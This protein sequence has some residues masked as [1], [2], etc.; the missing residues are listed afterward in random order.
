MAMCDECSCFDDS[1]IET[2]L[3]NV[4]ENHKD[5]ANDK[6][7]YWHGDIQEDY[8]MPPGYDCLCD[9]CFS[10]LKNKGKIIDINS[11]AWD[12]DKHG[13]FIPYKEEK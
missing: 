9:E 13:W 6:Y 2:A 4:T 10:T 12:K 5:Y 7:Y 3:E 8:Q 1:Y 11:P